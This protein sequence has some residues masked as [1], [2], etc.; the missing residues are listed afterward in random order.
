[1]V[2]PILVAENDNVVVVLEFPTFTKAS[3]SVF[4]YSHCRVDDIVTVPKKLEFAAL[5]FVWLVGCVVKTGKALTTI[6]CNVEGKLKQSFTKHL[7]V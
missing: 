4:L 2:E 7:A 3:L 1:V 6:V 5:Q